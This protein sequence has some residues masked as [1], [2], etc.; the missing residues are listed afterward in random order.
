MYTL[1][2]AKNVLTKL[3]KNGIC[4]RWFFLTKYKKKVVFIVQEKSF[5]S[6]LLGPMKIQST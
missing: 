6:E 3:Q 5:I 4:G 2:V 1:K